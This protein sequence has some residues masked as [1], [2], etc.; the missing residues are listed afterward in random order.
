MIGNDE[1]GAPAEANLGSRVTTAAAWMVGFRWLDR[2]IGLVSIAILARL[3]RPEDFGIVGYATLLICLLELFAGTS[4]DTELIRHKAA[5]RAYLNAAW[6]I[7]IARGLVLVA[8][9]LALARPA[10]EFFNEPE[11]A[12][13][14]GVLA[15]IPLFAGFENV[16]VIEFR[17]NLEFDREFKFLLTTRILGTLVTLALGFALRTY[18][19]L[20]IGSVLRALFRLALSFV[21]H[22]FR[23]RLSVEKVRAMFRFSRWM[24]IQNLASGIYE[25]LPGFVIGRELSSSALA[26]FNA[27]KELADLATTEL[28]AP[29][30][31]ALY[32]ALATLSHQHERVTDVMVQSTGMLALMTLPIPL[33]I[34]LVA[35]DLVPIFLG[36]QW[37]PVVGVLQPLAI[38]ASIASISTNSPLAYMALNRPHLA[39]IGGSLRLLALLAV[40]AATAPIHSLDAM[41]VAVASVNSVMIVVEYALVSRILRIDARRF[42]AVIWRPFVAGLTMCAAVWALRGSMPPPADLPGHAWSLAGCALVGVVTYSVSLFALWHVGGRRDGAERRLVSLIA[43]RRRRVQP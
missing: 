21:F 34:A 41:A 25:R 29:I 37:Q 39:A 6:T 8:L 4:T 42:L 43:G 27:G 1:I 32:P 23:P 14:I 28:R 13:V 24:I 12:T 22:P 20:V 9:M 2:L 3:L 35:D 33:G 7:N 10:A 11:V 38:A 31:R 36:A 5:D 19:A 26:F 18:W 17:K 16:G 30:R 15:A 40:L